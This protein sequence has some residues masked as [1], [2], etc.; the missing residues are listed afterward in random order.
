MRLRRKRSSGSFPIGVDQEQPIHLEGVAVLEELTSRGTVRDTRSP[1]SRL[2]LRE[3]EAAT[4]P[5]QEIAPH[6]HIEGLSVDPDAELRAWLSGIDAVS[7]RLE[8]RLGLALP[9]DGAARSRLSA[10]AGH[11]AKVPKAQGLD[12]GDRR[13]EREDHQPRDLDLIHALIRPEDPLGVKR[14]AFGARSRA[15]ETIVTN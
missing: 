2:H 15:L 14:S 6:L 11:P 13:D 5:H 3:V 8:D 4:A 7:R 9:R 1:S 12:G 10:P